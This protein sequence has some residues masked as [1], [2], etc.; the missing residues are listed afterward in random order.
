MKTFAVAKAIYLM[1]SM[2]L[3]DAQLSRLTKL[4]FKYLWNKNFNANRAPERI[5]RS[6][7]LAPM[8]HG[9]FGMMNIKELMNSLDLRSYGRLLVSR[10]PFLCQLKNQINSRNFFDHRVTVLADDK[11]KNSIELLN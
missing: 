7:M 8:S 2:S 10:H 9:G 1:Q 11:L 5:K 4:L 6:I 3:N